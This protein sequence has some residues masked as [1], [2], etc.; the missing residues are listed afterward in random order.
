VDV[1]NALYPTAS[2]IEAVMTDVSD[3]PVVMLNL[4]R[5]RAAAAY[6]DGR[7]TSLMGRQAY[8]LYASAVQKVVE[9][10]G[11]PTR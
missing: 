3:A 5:F 6:P 1:E 11:S 8:D 7:P 10:R 2:G 4:L 9:E